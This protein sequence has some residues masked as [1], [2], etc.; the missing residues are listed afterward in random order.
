M[1]R[2]LATVL[3]P[4]VLLAASACTTTNGGAGSAGGDSA[5]AAPVATL[6]PR[7]ESPPAS[8][9]VTPD[10]AGEPARIARLEREARALAR[11]TGCTRANACRT[12]PVGARAC[13]GPRSYVTFCAASTDTVA[14]LAKL[15][16]LERAE[17]AYNDRSGMMGTCEFRSPPGVSL[18]GGSC[19]ETSGTGAGRVP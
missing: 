1:T 18:V 12:A 8:Q 19:R 15:R 5:S 14:L 3:L 11:T 4:T 17:K 2:V 7:A 10:T 6:P 16:E 13:G 9:T